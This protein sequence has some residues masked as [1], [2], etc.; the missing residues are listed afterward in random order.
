MMLLGKRHVILGHPIV[1]RP[2][3]QFITTKLVAALDK[4]KVSD[5][6]ATHLLF[7]TAEALGHNIDNL[8]INRSSIHR[9]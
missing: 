1:Q 5:R 9:T 4:C 6:D 8:V 2:S 3:K 7:A